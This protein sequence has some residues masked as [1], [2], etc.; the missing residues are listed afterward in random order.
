MLSNLTHLGWNQSVHLLHWAYGLKV[1]DSLQTQYSCLSDRDFYWI[2]IVSLLREK[3]QKYNLHK[4]IRVKHNSWLWSVSQYFMMFTL[5]Y[6]SCK[7]NVSHCQ[8]YL[9][10]KIRTSE[11]SLVPQEMAMCTNGFVNTSN[12]TK[13]KANNTA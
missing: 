7:W 2:G 13:F 12:T 5:A 4:Y 11:A 1:F 3:I 8:K 6:V 9:A 10:V